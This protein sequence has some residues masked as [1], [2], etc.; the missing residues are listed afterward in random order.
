MGRERWQ[1]IL[2]LPEVS[3]VQRSEESMI[4]IVIAEHQF[5]RGRAAPVTNSGQEI[6]LLAIAPLLPHHPHE[7]SGIRGVEA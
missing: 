3:K 2:G 6:V 5:P 4:Q 7:Q 1:E